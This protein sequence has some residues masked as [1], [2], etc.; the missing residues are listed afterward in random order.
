MVHQ[1]QGQPQPLLHPQGEGLELLGPGGGQ[2]HQLQHLVHRLPAGYAPLEAVVLQILPGGEE[3]GEGGDLDHGPGAGPLG[4]EVLARRAEQLQ[5][6]PGGGGLAGGHPH[7]GGLARP[8]AAHQPVDIPPAYH[9]VQPVQGL[10]G[11][12]GL[13]Q[14]VGRQHRCVFRHS[15]SAFLFEL[16]P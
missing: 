9:Q 1:G 13:T 10:A 2:I 11:S 16:S 7:E 15:V 14:A 3:G 8:V 6:A 12:V 5:L 4:P